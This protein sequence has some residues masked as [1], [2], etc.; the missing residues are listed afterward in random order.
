MKK[1]IIA[2]L[3]AGVMAIS[4][5]ACGESSEKKE[6]SNSQQESTVKA[7]KNLLSVEITLPASLVGDSDAELNEETKEAGVKEITKNDDGSI[8]MKMTKASHKKLLSETKQ[9][10]DEGIEEI[11]EDKENYPSFDS[12][13]YNDNVTE[14][15][16][17]V[18]PSTYG[19][20]Q[21]MAALAFYIQGNMYQA[22]NAVPTDQLKTIVNF[23]NKDTGDVIETADSSQMKDSS[24]Q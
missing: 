6:S 14:F 24:A 22:L 19:G 5:I 10:I 15:T 9:A 7:N 8:T 21:S 16:V 11:L 18:N 4:I 17:K 20:L 1:K 23:V 12:I 3:L 13:T 2:M